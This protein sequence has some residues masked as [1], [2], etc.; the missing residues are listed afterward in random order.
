MVGNLSEWVQDWYGG[1]PGGSVTDPR[2]P[3]SG[4]GRA[5]RGGSWFQGARYCRASRRLNGQPGIRGSDLGFRLLRI[6][7]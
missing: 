7:P 1:Y 5:I 2:G 3:G 6:A 4:W